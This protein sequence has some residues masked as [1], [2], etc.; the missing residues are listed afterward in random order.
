MIANLIKQKI[1]LTKQLKLI[2]SCY[3]EFREIEEAQSILYA[4]QLDILAQELQLNAIKNSKSEIENLKSSI[5]K[6]IANNI[7][8]AASL[9]AYSLKDQLPESLKTMRLQNL[10]FQDTKMGSSFSRRFTK[11]LEMK[12]QNEAQIN[13]ITN[14][15]SQSQTQDILLTGT[16]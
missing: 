16:Y 1:C 9:L 15:T 2:N 11:D 12:L 13:A 3:P 6:A 8:E 14:L 7:S 10:S 5:E 4:I